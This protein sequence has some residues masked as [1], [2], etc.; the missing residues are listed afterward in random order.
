MRKSEN[1][2]IRIEYGNQKCLFEFI[3]GFVALIRFEKTKPIRQEGI[4]GQVLK[5]VKYC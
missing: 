3:R 4:A 2:G 1:Q 5:W